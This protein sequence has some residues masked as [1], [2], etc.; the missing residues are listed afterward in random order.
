MCDLCT[1]EYR[2]AL[3]GLMRGHRMGRRKTNFVCISKQ[4]FRQ[5]W[6]L[7][8]KREDNCLLLLRQQPVSLCVTV[9]YRFASLG[10][11]S[12]AI[13]D[14]M[15]LPSSIQSTGC[16]LLPCIFS[17]LCF[18]VWPRI[19]GLHG[20]GGRWPYPR[21]PTKWSGLV[22]RFLQ[23][24][25]V[26][27]MKSAGGF[28][29]QYLLCLIPQLVDSGAQSALGKRLAWPTAWCHVGAGLCQSPEERCRTASGTA[30]EGLNFPPWVSKPW[31][32]SS[33]LT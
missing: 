7:G 33:L 13:S 30:S 19:T 3:L 15:A 16:Q 22:I 12:S 11:F 9:G 2:G 32:H 23:A 25:W 14:P 31:S 28:C 26:V 10:P 4:G 8:P 20:E 21:T 6:K 1:Q 17:C 29:V 27:L 5:Q 24:S 18:G